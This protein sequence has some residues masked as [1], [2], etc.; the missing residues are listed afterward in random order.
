MALTAQETRRVIAATRQLPTIHPQERVEDFI[1]NILTLNQAQLAAYFPN[2]DPTSSL[3]TAV[4]E[5]TSE[6]ERLLRDECVVPDF[7][8]YQDVHKTFHIAGLHTYLTTKGVPARLLGRLAH[9]RVIR[10]ALRRMGDGH[11]LEALAAAIMNASCDYGEATR[12]SGDQGIDAIGWKQLV[13]I[14]PHFSHGDPS[15]FQ[16]LPGEKVFLFASSK[17][18]TDNKQARPKL[19]NPAHIRELVGGWVIQRSSVAKWQSVGIRMLSPV[20]M[21]LVTTYRLSEGAKAECRELGIHVWGIPELIYLTCSSAPD[22][23]FDSVNGYA[24]SASAFNTWWKNRDVSRLMA[25]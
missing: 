3:Q 9:H 5:L 2:P 6:R 16:S 20:Q 25:V 10:T 7:A 22:V 1:G 15:K 8:V 4:A 12:G 13:L 17:A 23:V 14:D 24:F 18:F 19:L 21:I 11:N